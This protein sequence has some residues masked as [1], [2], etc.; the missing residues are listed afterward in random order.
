MISS[1]VC[2]STNPHS[3]KP[4]R[5]AATRLG[6]AGVVPRSLPGEAGKKSGHQGAVGSAAED[7]LLADGSDLFEIQSPA[8][9]SSNLLRDHLNLKPA[10]TS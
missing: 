3:L 5:A 10:G 6:S 8:D 7:T 4:F 2:V 9:T 1:N